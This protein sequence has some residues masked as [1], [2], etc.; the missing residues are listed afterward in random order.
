MNLL[1]ILRNVIPGQSRT[2]PVHEQLTADAAAEQRVRLAKYKQGWR[3]YKGVP[4][5]ASMNEDG[6]AIT[7]VNFLRRNIDKVNWFAFGRP[8]KM[9]HYKYQNE[10]DVSLQCWGARRVE[11]MLRIGQFGSVTGDAYIMVAPA[12]VAEEI[13]QYNKDLVDYEVK[14]PAQVRVVALNPAY[15]TPTYDA[16]DSDVMIAMEIDIPLRKYES[17]SGQWV[18]TFYHQTI[19]KNEIITST[20]DSH[21]A[22]VPGSRK[23]QPNAIKAIY[24]VHIRNYPCGD[25]CFGLDDITEAASL[26][27]ALAGA[28]A[29]IG[30][31]LKYHGDP[32]T[33]IFG[34]K[35]SNLKKGPNKIW[36]NLP[37]DA[38]VE[39]LALQTDLAAANA[40]M[41][42]LKESLHATMGVPEIAQGTKQ[43]ISNT[44]GVALHTMY[45]PL[46]ER[47][48]TKHQIYGP[49]L[50]EVS[51]ISIKWLQE[52]GLMYQV[53]ADGTRK[54]KD[55]RTKKLDE[56]DFEVIRQEA[57]FRIGLPLP[58]DRL[59]E[60]QIQT[61]LMAA[62]LQTTRDA[63]V[64]LGESRPDEKEKE[65]IEEAA[66]KAEI[67]M[68][69]AIET[70]KAT[71]AGQP[72]DGKN[73]PAKIA[74][75]AGAN[76]G[77]NK[78]ESDTPKGRP[79]KG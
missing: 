8:F 36:G 79:K 42:T 46:I 59:I 16:F 56:Q 25:S 52:L 4:I 5:A 64:E 58:K 27:S 24:V 62:G 45:L 18:T 20:L 11:K 12:Q 69:T 38:K 35:S 53:D 50:V 34:A 37:K 60:A 6:T 71:G 13:L 3:D 15:C 44:S 1:D 51:I 74:S 31:I 66:A 54:A 73:T 39:N 14:V 47:A 28:I 49:A 43:A 55:G 61:T 68:Q 26:N 75:G 77:E 63:L 41:D 21:G 2:G 30:Q 67:A 9:T 23:A 65:I 29:N 40:H 32:I 17:S 7:Y 48:A 76:Q 33:V 10:L 22:E 57:E 19:T 70:S 78:T 72:V